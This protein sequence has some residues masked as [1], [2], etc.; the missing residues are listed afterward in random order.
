VRFLANENV[1]SSVIRELRVRGH[2]VLSA[3]ESMQ[4]KIDEVVL[5]RAQD[6]QR[7]LLTHD[8]DFGE[9]AY[10]SKLPATCGVILFRLTGA[11]PAV[12]TRRIIDAIESRSDWPGHFAVVSDDKIRMRSLPQ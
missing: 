4:G 12:D 7:I 5:A 2:D 6:E 11:D 8:K 9:L 10:R 1:A 3:K